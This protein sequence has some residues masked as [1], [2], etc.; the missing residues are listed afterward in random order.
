MLR[1]EQYTR[2]SHRRDGVRVAAAPALNNVL[3][4]FYIA[5]YFYEV[6][7]EQFDFRS[8]DPVTKLKATYFSVVRARLKA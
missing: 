3:R 2:L 8:D 5:A 4:S 1:D 7:G 6:L